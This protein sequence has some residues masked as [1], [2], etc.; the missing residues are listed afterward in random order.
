M[1]SVPVI[2]VLRRIPLVFLW[3]PG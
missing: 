2:F 1:K 3:F